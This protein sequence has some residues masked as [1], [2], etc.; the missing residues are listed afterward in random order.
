[1]GGPTVTLHPDEAVARGVAE[2]D[3]VMLSNEAGCLPLTVAISDTVQPGV[4]LVPKGRWPGA[5]AGD[6]NV[7]ALVTGRKSDIAEST[8]VHGTEVDLFRIVAK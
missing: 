1:L 3:Q 4:G 7:N 2:G 6:A 8:A 5:S